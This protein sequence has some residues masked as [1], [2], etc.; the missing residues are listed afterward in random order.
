MG[1]I[2]MNNIKT[3]FYK[4]KIF[5]FLI[6]MLQI[7]FLFFVMILEKKLWIISLLTL[8]DIFWIYC[9]IKV[10]YGNFD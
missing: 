4:N 9:L 6:I 7:I 10:D 3:K 2:F 5:W 8:T 1:C